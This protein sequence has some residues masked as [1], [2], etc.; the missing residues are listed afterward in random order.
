[1]KTIKGPEHRL[2]KIGQTVTGLIKYER[3]ELGWIAADEARGYA[4]RVSIDNQSHQPK[5]TGKLSQ[6]H[7]GRK[8]IEHNL[9]FLV[10]IG[11][12]PTR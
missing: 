10:D 5:C 8:L 11:C 3:I 2:F 6:I 4:E 1:M 9:N 12:Y 7:L